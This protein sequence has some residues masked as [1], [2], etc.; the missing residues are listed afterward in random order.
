MLLKICGYAVISWK[1][2]TVLKVTYCMQSVKPGQCV[3]Y[4]NSLNRL[5]EPH[6]SLWL[7]SKV[8]LTHSLFIHVAAGTSRLINSEPTGESAAAQ[9]CI[10]LSEPGARTQ[11]GRD[12]HSCPPGHVMV[13]LWTSDDRQSRW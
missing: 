3:R 7:R 1:D 4:R 13:I 10:H 6:S 11:G 9:I 8:P 2:Y 12:A 5:S